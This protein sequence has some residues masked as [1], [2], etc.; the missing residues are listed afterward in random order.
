[1]NELVTRTH[2]PARDIVRRILIT[3]WAVPAAASAIVGDAGQG[4]RG[5]V[6]SIVSARC[7]G[8][9]GNAELFRYTRGRRVGHRSPPRTLCACVVDEG[10]AGWM[11]SPGSAL[12][13]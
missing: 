4:T 6:L 12:N 2:R 3:R 11:R 1:V 7:T 10:R 8:A 9:Q 5:V 13:A